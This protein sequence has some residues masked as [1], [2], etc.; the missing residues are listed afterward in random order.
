MRPSL[1]TLFLRT[2]TLP[3]VVLLEWLKPIERFFRQCHQ[4]AIRFFADWKARMRR[5]FGFGGCTKAS[6]KR[7]TVPLRNHNRFMS[8][9]C[10]LRRLGQCCQTKVRKAPALQR[11]G[12]FHQL[13]CLHVHTKT[14]TRTAS[15]RF[16]EFVRD[17]VRVMAISPRW[18][19]VEC[20][21]PLG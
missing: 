1:R 10:G 19:T 9:N 2:L 21:R 3:V 5:A 12:S 14:E 8:S 11:S 13:L 20:V 16:S 7:V 6:K 17:E 4:E 18:L 15:S